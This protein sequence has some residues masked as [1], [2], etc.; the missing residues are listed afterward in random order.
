MTNAKHLGVSL[1]QERCHM[2]RD[3]PGEFYFLKG[4][5]E[6]LLQ[7]RVNFKANDITWVSI[8]WRIR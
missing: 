2:R 7:G 5:R 6:S 8:S 3:E 4:R 1:E